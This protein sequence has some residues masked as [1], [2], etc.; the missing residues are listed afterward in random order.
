MRLSGSPRA[1]GGVWQS[2]ARRP[3]SRT[4]G[5]Q[6]ARC[7]R[8][9]IKNSEMPLD[10]CRAFG[11][12]GLPVLIGTEAMCEALEHGF[13]GFVTGALARAPSAAW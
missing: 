3:V 5:L 13:A 1:C 6:T 7:A 4:G 8:Q 10:E 2:T 9:G 12:G 11:K